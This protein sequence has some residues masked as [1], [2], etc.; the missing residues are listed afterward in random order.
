AP[1]P[2]TVGAEGRVI[3]VV[4]IYSPKPRKWTEEEFRV[5][6]WL[7]A[8]VAMT[9]QSIEFQRELI[10][11]RREAEEGSLQKTRF[12]A[13]V[14]HDVRTPANAISLIADLIERAADD[15]GQLP[16]LPEM[17]RGLKSSARAL[18]ELVSD[19]LDLARFDAGRFDLQVSDFNVVSLIRAEVQQF[20]P[21]AESKGMCRT[22][23]VPTEPVWL[24]TAKLKLASALKNLVD[25]AV[26]FTEVTAVEV[27]LNPR[28]HG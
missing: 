11:K 6:E 28:R 17:V 4:E 25:N 1:L 8:Q 20:E 13:A 21:M 15:P 24:R 23:V 5:I 10:Q 19:V 18:V 27:S 9:L 3:G 16:D 7:A 22:A 26:K 12:L 2:I 14:S